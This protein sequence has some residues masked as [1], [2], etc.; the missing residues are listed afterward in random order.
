MVIVHVPC[1]KVR[2]HWTSLT[3]ENSIFEKQM[4]KIFHKENQNNLGKIKNMFGNEM[5]NR[6]K[7]SFKYYNNYEKMRIIRTQFKTNLTL[8]K[9]KVH[10]N[11]QT[12]FTTAS[13]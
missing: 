1:D 9:C 5:P 8:Q 11:F 4:F 10:S 7:L 2:N 6:N 13:I 12:I 3:I